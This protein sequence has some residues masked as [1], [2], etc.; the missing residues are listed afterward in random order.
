VA[1]LRLLLHQCK[2]TCIGQA[3][4]YICSHAALCDSEERLRIAHMHNS[5]RIPCTSTSNSSYWITATKACLEE[6]VALEYGMRT[7]YPSNRGKG[8]ND[9]SPSKLCCCCL[10]TSII[11]SLLTTRS[12]ATHHSN[13]Y[14]SPKSSSLSITQLP[15]VHHEGTRYDRRTCIDDA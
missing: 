2:E 9:R 6:H 10:L 7:R 13:A 14:V 15:P 3:N 1:L 12:P 11:L 8:K 4:L 5:T